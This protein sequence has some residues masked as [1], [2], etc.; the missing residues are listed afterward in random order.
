[1]TFTNVIPPLRTFVS[2]RGATRCQAHLLPIPLNSLKV[3]AGAVQVV[4]APT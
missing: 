4:T 2:P 1:M 3:G